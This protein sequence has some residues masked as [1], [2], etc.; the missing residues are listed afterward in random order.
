MKT[1]IGW[2]SISRC[3]QDFEQQVLHGGAAMLQH[4]TAAGKSF[5]RD[6]TILLIARMPFDEVARTMTRGGS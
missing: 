3:K 1:R 2:R 5:G 6:A 4:V